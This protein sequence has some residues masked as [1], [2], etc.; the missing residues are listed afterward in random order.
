MTS[1]LR[2]PPHRAAGCALAIAAS[3]P[4]VA[5]AQP[6]PAYDALIARLNETPPALEASALTE[7]AEARVRQA[8]VRPNP[9]LSVDAENLLGSGP[10]SGYDNA[11]T[12]VSLSRALD[13]WG[14][15]RARIDAAQAEA[16]AVSAQGNLARLDASGRL[17]L[18]YAEAETAQR[19]FV[20][21]QE[22]LSL[23]EADAR[24]ANALVESG[25]E[26]PLRGIQARTEAA[27]A[28]ATLDEARAEQD[29]AFARLT[30]V[31]LLPE[32][33]TAIETSL[34]ER[35]PA[36][37]AASVAAP[38]VRVAEAERVAAERR[39]AAQ[40]TLARPDIT[41]S[42]GLR[43]FEAE[44]ATAAMVGFSVPLPLFDRNR[45]N[46]DAARAEF[47]ASEARL[48]A[49]VRDAEAARQAA[50]ARL[51]ASAGRV[52]A[53][54]AAAA[55]A[56]EAYRL[57]RIGAEAGRVSQL[58]LRASRTALIAARNLALD[59]R[60][61]RVRAEIDLARLQSRTPFGGAL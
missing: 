34:L 54:D 55:S 38:T 48:T 4:G 13:L 50:L 39:I 7:A 30:A 40:R 17:A 26:A 5:W 32:P 1:L 35:P 49:A 52:E 19:R 14:R 46:I 24:D 36:E 20:L 61:A 3:L 31:A 22:Q 41:A 43:R 28:L 8:R 2:R 37:T 25:R 60:L 29:A 9:V 45:G 10:Y 59:A 27:A 47:R 12:T 53:A 58:E 21:A 11:E 6:A 15:R 51:S 33:V 44:N 16:G 23:T 56:D 18:A 42:F 57:T